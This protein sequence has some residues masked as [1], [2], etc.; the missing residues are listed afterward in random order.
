MRAQCRCANRSFAS[1]AMNPGSGHAVVAS[2]RFAGEDEW[3]ATSAIPE[4][5]ASPILGGDFK[6][7][8]KR[9][10]GVELVFD[11]SALQCNRRDMGFSGS[12]CC[13]ELKIQPDNARIE[14]RNYNLNPDEWWTRRSPAVHHKHHA[15]QIDHW[16]SC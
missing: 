6:I 11:S 14:R 3:S 15:P 12:C 10:S 7:D 13:E 2:V 1:V 9:G 16:V 4:V 5:A 8:T